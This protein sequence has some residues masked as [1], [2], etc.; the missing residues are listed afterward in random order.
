M[1]GAATVR[2]GSGYT[3]GDGWITSAV[4]P[5]LG[6]FMRCQVADRKT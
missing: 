2:E 1:G 5:Q 3:P 4:C 6:V